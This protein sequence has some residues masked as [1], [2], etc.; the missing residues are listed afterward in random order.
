M[1]IIKPLQTVCSDPKCRR[2]QNVP[3]DR[4]W[5]VDVRKGPG[6]HREAGWTCRWC[7]KDNTTPP[8]HLPKGLIQSL[9]SRQVVEDRV[10]AAAR[11]RA[12]ASRATSVPKSA[13]VVVAEAPRTVGPLPVEIATHEET[14][15][16]EAPRATSRA[17]E[18]AREIE[19]RSVIRIETVKDDGVEAASG[20]RIVEEPA[21]LGRPAPTWVVGP[22]AKT[23]LIEALTRIARH[24]GDAVAISNGDDGFEAVD[25][26][27]PDDE[28]MNES[29][30]SSLADIVLDELG[31]MRADV[32][33]LGGNVRGRPWQAILHFTAGAVTF[34]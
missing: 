12:E 1:T 10:E 32:L 11:E 6:S 20:G 31:E 2:R 25:V 5:Y 28:D 7:G 21:I 19:M 29:E 33:V 3:I 17:V 27:M 13:P 22:A 14:E 24:G 18:I 8:T 26:T 4:V 9:P 16:H 30:L 23:A 15:E 34:P